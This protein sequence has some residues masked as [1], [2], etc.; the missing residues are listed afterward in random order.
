MVGP[1]Q[2]LGR[3]LT[4]IPNRVQAYTVNILGSVVGVVLFALFAMWELSPLW[5]FLLVAVGISYFLVPRPFAGWA[6]L[7]WGMLSLL[8][9]PAL[10]M[11]NLTSG[12]HSRQ[13]ESAWQFFKESVQNLA[14]LGNPPIPE[15]TPVRQCLWSPYYRVDYSPAPSRS[16]MVNLIGHQWMSSRDTSGVSAYALPHLVN[17]DS[18]GK[19]FNKVLIIGAGSGNDV[20]RALQWGAEHIDA[21]EI[22][23]VI[24]RL[25]ARDHP[26]KPYQGPRVKVHLDDGRNFLRSAAAEQ[27]DLVIYALLDSLVLH[28]SYSNIRLE[29]YL[30]TR[31]AFADVKRC[32][33]KDG[34][35]AM[36]NYYRQ[37]WI[38]ARLNLGLEEVF[39]KGNP[40]A[41][42]LPYLKTV[43]EGSAGGFTLFFAGHTKP[44]REQFEKHPEYWMNRAGPRGPDTPNGFLLKPVGPRESW[45]RLGIAEVIAPREPLR[46]ATDDWP[47]LYLRRP[48]IPNV[49]LGGAAVMGGLALVLVLAFLPRGAAG[50]GRWS[51]DGRMFFLGAGFMLVETKAVV[52][53]ALLFGSTWM[54]NSVVFFAVLVM[55]LAA[56]L[57]VLRYRP[58]NLWPYYAG[59][60]VT[61]G[62]NAAIPL[63]SFLGMN[64]PAQVVGSCL[65]VF[66]PILFAGTIFAVAFARSM[67][68]DLAFGANI[69]GAMLGGLAEYTSMLLGFQY[70]MLVAIAFYLLS[71]L[72]GWGAAAMPGQAATTPG[73]VPATS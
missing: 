46:T 33:K 42:T 66:A 67:Q 36:Y 15:G 13:K 40:L 32:L 55:I 47:F 41:L 30:F 22:D 6:A 24:Q 26:D 23:P 63:D 34:L 21:V 72:L 17:R 8:L 5:W 59:L 2:E 58:Q 45:L 68:A 19:P 25:G 11:G 7:R 43:D 73:P 56:N 69:A 12:V 18:G 49:S 71:G 10:L 31:Q 9:L 20:S 61:L 48:M 38:L 16:I 4:R 52:H 35:L 44:I 57:F 53:M 50:V 54:V 29:S 3:A 27:Y 28:S 37:G 62:L 1:G 39:G 70:L 64:R 60:L 14:T 51:L 65:L